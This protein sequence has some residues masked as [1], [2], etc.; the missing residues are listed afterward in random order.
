MILNIIDH[1]IILYGTLLGTMRLLVGGTALRNE[2]IGR[3]CRPLLSKGGV[4]AWRDRGMADKEI[5]M[6]GHDK[7]G[8]CRPTLP[9]YC[10]C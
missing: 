5:G 1:V 9:R 10:V 2:V 3:G 6:A 7:A 8:R 4:T